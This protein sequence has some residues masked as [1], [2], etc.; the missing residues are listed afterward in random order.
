[1]YI[2]KKNYLHRTAWKLFVS[3]R[4]V[5]MQ[6]NLLAEK[7]AQL[8]RQQEVGSKESRKCACCS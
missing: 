7:D 8:A 5:A 3:Q 1:M 2:L 6:S 4:E